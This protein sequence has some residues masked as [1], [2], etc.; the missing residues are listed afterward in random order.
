MIRDQQA[1]RRKI[2]LRS[3]LDI[4]RRRVRSHHLCNHWARSAMVRGPRKRRKE[5]APAAC[6]ELPSN[7]SSRH[8][9]RG[10]SNGE[11]DCII[12]SKSR[13]KRLGYLTI[14]DGARSPIP[15]NGVSLSIEDHLV[16]IKLWGRRKQQIEIFQGF[17]E[18]KTGHFIF[19]S[20]LFNATQ[21]GVASLCSTVLYE[22]IEE[23]SPHLY[24]VRV[25]CELVQ[26]VCRLNNL[27]TK[28]VAVVC[29]FHRGVIEFLRLNTKM[30][31]DLVKG[32]FR[33]SGATEIARERQFSRKECIQRP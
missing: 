25:L 21:A 24:I 8:S 17:G 3:Y 27:R 33:S 6:P 9:D 4:K 10:H 20:F 28:L 32:L 11:R 12:G 7:V 19:L 22:A 29:N 15:P 16:E 23:R 5:K 30:R 14:R 26:V 18:K 31:P 2:S 1:A 13:T